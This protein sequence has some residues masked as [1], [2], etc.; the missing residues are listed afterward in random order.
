[1][2]IDFVQETLTETQTIETEGGMKTNDG[3]RRRTAGGVFFYIVK[4]KLSPEQRAII[5]P[6]IDWKKRRA[7]KKIKN[8][9]PKAEEKQ[10]ATV[11]V[12]EAE[13]IPLAKPEAP[14]SKVPLEDSDK[15]AKLESA[16]RTLRGRLAE[17]EAKG[18]KGVKMTKN[19]LTNT[20]KQ[21]EVLL[22]ENT[23]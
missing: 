16:A 23:E 2:G 3:K 1:M 22:K 12:A 20:E 9:A 17:M 21:I 15:L 13:N 18:Q 8:K 14:S 6:P 7:K 10:V 11:I 4:P 19:L 5:F